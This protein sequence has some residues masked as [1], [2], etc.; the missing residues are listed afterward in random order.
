MPGGVARNVE[1]AEADPECIDADRVALDEAGGDPG[2]RFPRR[3]VDWRIARQRS[4]AADVV[5]MMVGDQDGRERQSV[6]RTGA[7]N[8]PYSV[9]ITGA[10]SALASE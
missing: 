10:T 2:N 3:P 1:D 7:Q 4:D 6:L 5:V 9:S 8:S